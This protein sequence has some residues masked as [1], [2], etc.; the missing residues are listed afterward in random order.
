VEREGREAPCRTHEIPLGHPAHPDE[1]ASA[2]DEASAALLAQRYGYAAREVLAMA[3]GDQSLRGRIVPDLPDLLAELPFAARHEQA[4]T[5]ADGL[6][7]R[8]R[9]GILDAARLV[10]P[11]GPEARAAAVAM[12]GE[13]GWDDARVSRE[14]EEWRAV[15]SAEGLTGAAAPAEGAGVT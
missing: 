11:D 9:L 10:A 5:L 12:G 6:L 7:R 14:L 8:T 15:A 2:G 13:L 1:L 3:D 4:V